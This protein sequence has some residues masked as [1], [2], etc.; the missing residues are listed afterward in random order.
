MASDIAKAI[1]DARQKDQSVS[2]EVSIGTW[3]RL[4]R[5]APESTHICA[6][7]GNRYDMYARYSNA[8]PLLKKA[9]SLQAQNPLYRLMLCRLLDHMQRRDEMLEI[10]NTALND[11]PGNRNV[12]DQYI[13]RLITLGEFHKAKNV[14]LGDL[15]KT[16]DMT[17]VAQRI[18]PSDVLRMA[19]IYTQSENDDVCVDFINAVTKN[20][21]SKTSLNALMRIAQSISSPSRLLPM[22]ESHY[23]SDPSNFKAIQIYFGGLMDAGK[24]GQADAIRNDFIESNTPHLKQSNVSLPEMLNNTAQMPQ[25]RNLLDLAVWRSWQLF[26]RGKVSWTNWTNALFEDAR[27]RNAANQFMFLRPDH[28]SASN[29]TLT[30]ASEE[31]LKSYLAQDG[32]AM[33][34]GTH[35]GPAAIAGQ[36]FERRVDKYAS[37]TTSTQ[38]LINSYG[39]SISAQQGSFSLMRDIMQRLSDGYLISSAADN[40][41][42]ADSQ[43][44]DFSSN[45]IAGQIKLSTMIP[46]L[47]FKTKCPSFF[48]GLEWDSAKARIVI[49]DLP[50]PKPGE[51]KGDFVVRWMVG[52]LSHLK[53]SITDKPENIN[54]WQP[55]WSDMILEDQSV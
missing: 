40:A 19:K 3:E 36:F 24:I 31:K 25:K 28:Y 11:F 18:T 26:G 23:R 47:A 21:N 7:L 16:D 15:D 43:Y 6:M 12:R 48:C 54:A 20:H 35:Q 9:S 46:R 53:A 14:L 39:K 50:Q 8:L 51:G 29:Y 37:V 45:G 55:I 10:Y 30:Q 1:R 38:N 2:P 22:M 17:A 52:Y 41:I 49:E 5:Q 34:A 44:F 42:T 32:G 13:G 27:R 4:H 33:M